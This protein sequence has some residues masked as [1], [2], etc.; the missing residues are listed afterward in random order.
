MNNNPLCLQNRPLQ[1]Y[2]RAL[3]KGNL[4]ALP[5]DRYIYYSTYMVHK[6]AT[7]DKNRVLVLVRPVS[8][9]MSWAGAGKPVSAPSIIQYHD[10]ALS[11]GWEGWTERFNLILSSNHPVVSLCSETTHA[12]AEA[13]N[14]WRQRWSSGPST[15]LHHTPPRNQVSLT[16]LNELILGKAQQSWINIYLREM[17]SWR[18]QIEAVTLQ[19]QWEW[20]LCYMPLPTPNFGELLP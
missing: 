10:E 12:A 16:K 11:Y 1:I 3:A 7:T 19:Q 18:N 13:K 6:H 4:I 20:L 9:R 17:V 8:A 2:L 14:C 15:P 5:G